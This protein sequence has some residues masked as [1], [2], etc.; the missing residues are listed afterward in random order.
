MADLNDM[1]DWGRLQEML[2]KKNTGS[3]TRIDEAGLLAHL[4]T[5]V[6]GQDAILQDVAKIIR[7]QAAKKQKEK[8]IADLL[9]LGPTGTGKTELAKAIAEYLFKDEKAMIRFDCSELN[10]PESK[11]RLIGSPTGY[12]GSEQGGQLTRPVMANPRRLILFDEI[13]KAY[14]PVFDLFLQLM[15][16]ARLTEQ[17]SG[18]AVDFSQTIIILTSNAHAEQIGQI[19]REVTDYHDMVNSIKTYLAESKVFRP[20][21]VG[22]IDRVYVFQPLS[23]MIIAEIALLKITKLAEQY[24]LRV[25]FV[26]PELL[27]RALA[28]NEKVSRFG[29]RELE[30]ILDEMLAN[31]MLQAKDQGAREVVLEANEAG[32]VVVVPSG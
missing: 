16:E 22:R 25:H 9:F 14:P 32:E 2:A 8:P 19:Q 24:R 28:A 23:G 6:K 12:I 7:L 26:A 15:G 17:G 1:T 4:R 11:T 10:G 13:E 5:R 20:E 21:I 29:I 31:Q 3:T 30:R 18:K 27:M